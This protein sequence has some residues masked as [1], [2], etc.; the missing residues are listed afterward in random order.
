[1]I[2][3]TELTDVA[4][5]H[6]TVAPPYH[7]SFFVEVQYTSST[8]QCKYTVLTSFHC[9][10]HRLHYDYKSKHDTRL[11]CQ[12]HKP[13][14]SDAYQPDQLGRSSASPDKS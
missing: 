5:R 7:S 14:S 8:R 6:V 1:M 9:P 4:P 11:C 12:E 3:I 13:Q 10:A 2:P